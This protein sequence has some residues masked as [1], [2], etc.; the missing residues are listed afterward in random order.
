MDFLAAARVN[1]G[2][3]FSILSV[4]RTMFIDGSLVLCQQHSCTREF[5]RPNALGRH[6]KS[7]GQP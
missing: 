3:G 6:P 7:S 2:R 5:N 1:I 4:K